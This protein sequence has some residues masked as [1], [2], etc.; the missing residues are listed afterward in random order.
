ME[1]ES[2]NFLYW[3]K[4]ELDARQQQLGFGI[5]ANDELHGDIEYYYIVEH[6]AGDTVVRAHAVEHDAGVVRVGGVVQEVAVPQ[7]FFSSLSAFRCPLA[8]EPALVLAR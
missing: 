2:A 7:P 4:R 3:S 5:C 1:Y 6:V 8:S